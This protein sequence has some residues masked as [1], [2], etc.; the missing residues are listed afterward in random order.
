MLDRQD[1]EAFTAYSNQGVRNTWRATSMSQ[2]F[3]ENS[4]IYGTYN[5]RYNSTIL[6]LTKS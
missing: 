1:A 3:D 6:V 5:Y 4:R 2:R